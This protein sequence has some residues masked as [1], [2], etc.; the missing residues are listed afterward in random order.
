MTDYNRGM[1]ALD[2][3]VNDGNG[4]GN[5]NGNWDRSRSAS[6]DIPD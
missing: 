6:E 1:Q 2:R 4:I 3:L 5:G